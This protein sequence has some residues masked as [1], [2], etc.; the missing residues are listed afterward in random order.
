MSPSEEPDPELGIEALLR[1]CGADP[2]ALERARR[3]L[4]QLRGRAE[5]AE[6]IVQATGHA[7]LW[8]DPRGEILE[9][10]AA[11]QR[12]ATRCGLRLGPGQRITEALSAR[13][14][15]VLRAAGARASG[16][17][18]LLELELG[19]VHA[20]ELHQVRV[21][22]WR[23]AHG[24]L[25]GF[26]LT[27]TAADDSPRDLLGRAHATL[28]QEGAALVDA[29]GTLSFASPRFAELVGVPD[30][31]ELVGTRVE[32]LFVATPSANGDIA[33]A[34]VHLR[35]SGRALRLASTPLMR[36][37]QRL[38][39]AL[40][41][42]DLPATPGTS[43]AEDLVRALAASNEDMPF[44][45]ALIDAT[46]GLRLALGSPALLEAVLGDAPR[47]LDD[48][49]GA[50]AV[51]IT[52]RGDAA[53]GEALGRAR[54]GQVAS[55]EL[56]T[57]SGPHI[58]LRFLPVGGGGFVL[59]LGD[60][61]VR[62][63]LERRLAAARRMEVLGRLT[64]GVAHDFN[65]LLTVIVSYAESL[66]YE[67][68]EIDPRRRDVDEIR[69]AAGRAVTLSRQLLTFSQRQPGRA[70]T[71]DL[72]R[73][74]EGVGRL[75]ERVIGAS[76][77][78]RLRLDEDLG[79]VR[80]DSAQIEQIL[81]NLAL[82]ARDA[83][84]SGGQLAIATAN[85]Y[86]DTARAAALGLDSGHY[87]RLSIS[88]SGAPLDDDAR[89]SLLGTATDDGQRPDSSMLAVRAATHQSGG[90]LSVEPGEEGRGSRVDVFLPWAEQPAPGAMA[91]P[92]ASP[93]PSA[94][95]AVAPAADDDDA[96]QGTR[97]PRGAPSLTIL[98]VEDDSALRR[99]TAR[100]LRDQGYEVLAARDGEHALAK[101]SLHER[102]VDLLVT[103]IVMP[104]MGGREVAAQL[105]RLN[106]E[107][108]VLFTSGYTE[109]PI[110][111]DDPRAATSFLPKPYTRSALLRDVRTLLQQSRS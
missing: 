106:P 101:V 23:A 6:R 95:T 60:A 63:E 21:D 98:L 70:H 43:A 86:L 22:A 15:P 32:E 44:A 41:V 5:R 47:R 17:S 79:A 77:E 25:E 37:G 31:R 2:A 81:L 50:T 64:E 74:I 96:P 67:L 48:T 53:L 36:R 65:N 69:V 85:V 19:P 83:M 10:N 20:R 104:R 28:S 55:A 99:L 68:P 39:Q 84:P 12:L 109:Q 46:G 62:S 92:A 59:A 61:T 40:V 88:D 49:P 13:L 16:D 3:L 110:T 26:V 93:H 45:L 35:A 89:Q 82:R 75:L 78:I 58:H 54:K 4:H 94:H 76:I 91:N 51:D 57:G 72:N 30:A 9:C 38:G 107:L 97:A 108:R 33:R 100:V 73:S 87:V 102:P 105:L 90:A 103:D 71:V 52:W 24:E 27:L 18:V 1:E 42:S 29:S 8:L 7:V 56:A 11:A 66:R 80:L 14:A 34:T 111:L